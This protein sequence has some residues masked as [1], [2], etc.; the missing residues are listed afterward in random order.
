MEAVRRSCPLPL[1][2][3]EA[4]H[5]QST[6]FGEQPPE[7]SL[8]AEAQSMSAAILP[9]LLERHPNLGKMYSQ[10]GA[11]ST[12]QASMR[13]AAWPSGHF[14]PLADLLWHY[15]EIA[16]SIVTAAVAIDSA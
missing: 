11:K 5:F 1:K 12:L 10:S 3:V 13:H 16:G 4:R 14:V 6:V 15:E 8:V 9:H 2:D 7:G